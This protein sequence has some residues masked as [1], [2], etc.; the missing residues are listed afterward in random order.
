MLQQV[1]TM[2]LKRGID[3][4]VTK[5]V[6]SLRAQTET[7]G[8]DFSKIEQIGTQYQLIMMPLLVN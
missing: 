1:L 2:D 3:K 5:V 7:V 4:A 8:S 6:D